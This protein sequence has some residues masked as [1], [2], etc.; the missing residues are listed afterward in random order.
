MKQQKRQLTRA[1][2]ELTRDR[3]ALERQEK[4][5]VSMLNCRPG[6]G[7]VLPRTGSCFCGFGMKNNEN[8]AEMLVCK[9]LSLFSIHRFNSF[10][11]E[12]DIKKAAK[13]G[14]R[15][16]ISSSVATHFSVTP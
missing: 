13:Q 14:N 12:N 2:R 15:Q 9:L 6:T 10:L 1:Q 8:S 11:Q 4:Q 5:L 7:D 3:G 16:V